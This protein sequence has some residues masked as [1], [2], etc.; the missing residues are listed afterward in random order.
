MR[1]DL[2]RVRFGS[3][4]R[5]R[6]ISGKLSRKDKKTGGD[7]HQDEVLRHIHGLDVRYSPLKETQSHE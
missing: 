3:S 6:Q 1:L 5:G 7:H 2:L 4:Q